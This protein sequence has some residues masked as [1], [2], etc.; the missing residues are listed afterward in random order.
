MHKQKDNNRIRCCFPWCCM[1][2]LE[3]HKILLMILMWDMLL[4][5]SWFIYNINYIEKISIAPMIVNML[6]MVF[7][8]F[9]LWNLRNPLG[10]LTWITIYSYI[11]VIT[12]V[13]CCIACV[14]AFLL[15]FVFWGS[16]SSE[17]SGFLT[18][19]STFW[20]FFFLLPISLTQVGS[21]KQMFK[22]LK[23]LKILRENDI[24]SPEYT[25]ARINASY[26]QNVTTYNNNAT[27]T[28][29]ISEKKKNI[30]RI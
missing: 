10:K 24:E 4:F 16:P 6:F 13:I 30:L 8:T 22:S 9:V 20:I 7:M 19:W 11:R 3:P 26:N 14:V 18:I 2:Y 28:K 29:P 15:I 21:M 17:I 5:L 27:F 12:T 1:G 23:R 25:E